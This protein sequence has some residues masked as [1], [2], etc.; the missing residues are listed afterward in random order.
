VTYAGS[1]HS[2]FDR[3]IKLGAATFDAVYPGIPGTETLLPLLFAEGVNTGRITLER[4]ASFT[5]GNAARVFQLQ[6]KGAIQPGY[7]ADLVVIDPAKEIT[8]SSTMLHSRCDYT[9]YEG[10]HLR[11]YPVATLSRGEVVMRDG[12]FRGRA[13]RGRLVDRAV[14]SRSTQLASARLS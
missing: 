3:S 13:G 14:D 10:Q 12:E 9:P 11:G 6:R 4:F 8:L 1:D 5:S 2:P 7:D